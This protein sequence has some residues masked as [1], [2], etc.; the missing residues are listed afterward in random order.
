MKNKAFDLKKYKFSDRDEF[1]FDANVWIYLFP[2]PTNTA[3][4]FGAAYT[5]AVKGMLSARSRLALDPLVLSEYLNSYCRIEWAGL[6]RRTYPVYKAFRQSPAFASVG[7]GA[8][9]FAKRIISL[10]SRRDHPFA[11]VDIARVL[12]DFESGA[13]DFNDG[14]IAETCRINGWM[15]VTNDGDFTTGGIELLTAHP[16]LLRACP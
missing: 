2:G 11:G 8:A 13:Q 4:R 16:V 6:H 12:V 14:L 10:C 3:S 15:L 9:L 5:A 7:Q 1:L